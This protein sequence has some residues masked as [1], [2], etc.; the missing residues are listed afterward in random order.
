MSDGVARKRPLSAGESDAPTERAIAVTPEAAEY[1]STDAASRRRGHIRVREHGGHSAMDLRDK[2]DPQTRC[3]A[4]VIPS[5][6][7]EFLVGFR[8]EQLGSHEISA[9]A[10]RNT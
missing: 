7:A 6:L 3:L 10:R 5:S 9:I 4:L 8:K 2:G 1:S